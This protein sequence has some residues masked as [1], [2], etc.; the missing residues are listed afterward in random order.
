MREPLLG[1]GSGLSG[2][3]DGGG[4]AWSRWQWAVWA[5]PKCGVL[6]AELSLSPPGSTMGG[7]TEGQWS[8]PES[9]PLPRRL[10]G[11]SWQQPPQDTDVRSL[12]QSQPE[13]WPGPPGP[14]TGSEPCGAARSSPG[15]GSVLETYLSWVRSDRT[16]GA[17]SDSPR[18]IITKRSERVDSAEDQS[19]TQQSGD[20]TGP[21]GCGHRTL[22]FP[23]RTCVALGSAPVEPG[24]GE[25]EGNGAQSAGLTWML[26]FFLRLTF[27]ERGEGRER[28]RNT[29]VWLPLLHPLLGPGPQHRHVP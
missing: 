9:L 22:G 13:D 14:R 4:S 16:V 19:P 27:L 2:L 17:S 12:K 28:E 5:A 25:K 6:G 26:L 29:N 15:L 10:C 7:R 20:V 21:R 1:R 18:K 23:P 3:V 11:S 24:A 8:V